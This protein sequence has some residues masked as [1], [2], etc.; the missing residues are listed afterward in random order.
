MTRIA[1]AQTDKVAPLTV[2][3]ALT[4]RLNLNGKKVAIIG[5]LIE[6]EA[7]SDSDTALV[8]D[9]CATSIVT[10]AVS[11]YGT[12]KTTWPN[13]I[14]LANLERA[15]A[16]LILANDA[17]STKVRM[18]E[19]STQRGCYQARRFD[20]DTGKWDTTKWRYQW[21]IALG[22]FTTRADLH[23]ERGKPELP[24]WEPANGFGT[25]NTAPAYLWLNDYKITTLGERER[26][27]Q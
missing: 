19:R 1:D 4:D 16:P 6:R 14:P 11:P 12:W 27:S 25:M 22:I 21:A 10:E 7:L 3:E 20:R 18:L 24:G 13:R 26:C 17:V 9:Q 8:E 5:K 2:C 23:T 15:D